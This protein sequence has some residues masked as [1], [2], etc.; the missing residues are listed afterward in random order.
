MPNY[1]VNPYN[2]IPFGEGPERRSLAESFQAP[3]ESG[4]IDVLLT[5]KTPLIIPDASHPDSEPLPNQKKD[6]TG[7]PP[8]HNSYRFFRDAAGKPAIPG[9]SL[10]GML[11]SVYEAA[12]D[13]CL[14]FLLKNDPKHPISQRT[15]LFAAFKNRGL[16]CYDRKTRI[17]SLYSAK[18]SII[19]ATKSEVCTG[20]FRE[21][22]NGEDVSFAVREDGSVSLDCG[23]E[24]GWLQFNIPVD[25]D[26]PYHVAILQPRKL[27]Y[28]EKESDLPEG[29]VSMYQSLHTAV[30]DTNLNNNQSSLVSTLGKLG[31]LLEEVKTKGGVIPCYFFIVERDQKK[32]VYLSGAA[33]GRVRQ[34]R[35][36][37][38]I[39]GRHGPCEELEQLCPACS[40]FGTVKDEGNAGHLS[41]SD[42]EAVKYSEPQARTLPI[43]ST[44]RTSS[45]EFYL[46][47]PDPAATYWNF[48]YYGVKASYSFEKDGKKKE[49]SYTEYRDLDEATPRGRKMYWHGQPQ[50]STQKTKLNASM[51]VVDSG[52]FRFRIGFDRITHKQLGDLLWCVTLGE[53]Q[54]LEDGAH[55]LHKLGHGK[56]VGYGSVKLTVDK[57]FLREVKPD[58]GFSVRYVPCEAEELMLDGRDSAL[59]RPQMDAILRMTDLQATV[60]KTVAYP[61]GFDNRGRETIY[62]WFGANRMSAED[63]L[64]LPEP[65][66]ETITLPTH[67]GKRTPKAPYSQ[68]GQPK[69]KQ[70]APQ[71]DKAP[72]QA[73]LPVG[74]EKVGDVVICKVVGSN[75]LGL[76]VELGSG[77]KGT[78]L[79]KSLLK[80]INQYKTDSLLTAKIQ[81]DRFGLITL[82]EEKK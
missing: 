65:T 74:S 68:N 79:T 21:H 45:F 42:A 34:H 15:P 80:P 56:P 62:A 50:T 64:P 33:V 3:L 27:E 18:A 55:Q 76:S 38:D 77:K 10:R 16:L 5:V 78:V 7:K 47:K 24:K 13:S 43:L 63:V 54:A 58:A 61:T 72:K 46:R 48:D 75:N 49:V 39:M 31:Y 52:T 30:S 1:A 51:E 23:P 81:S 9:S 66:D 25:P 22:T 2:F 37:P 41:F 14:P 36:W 8:S 29:A 35:R 40:L 20:R 19:E 4:W 59:L 70:F 53:N 71:S 12:T 57:V 82:S 60:G 28:E 32:L 69:K 6:K 73:A 26:Q 11:R 17:W 44:P 67:R